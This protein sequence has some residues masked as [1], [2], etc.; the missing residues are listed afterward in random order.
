MAK[1][2]D[3]IVALKEALKSLHLPSLDSMLES[4]D[5][6]KSLLQDDGVAR[7]IVARLTEPSSGHSQDPVCRWLYDTFQTFDSGLQTVVL[8]SVFILPQIQIF[9]FEFPLLS[10][11]VRKA[12]IPDVE[13]PHW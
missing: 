2:R 6:S 10:I 11:L 1:A 5:P 4:P 7:E 9:C 8:R 13:M 12:L 3:R